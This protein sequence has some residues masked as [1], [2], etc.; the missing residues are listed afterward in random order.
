MKVA[1]ADCIWGNPFKIGPEDDREAVI[2]KYRNWLEND[3][4][5]QETA[6]RAK[7]ELKGKVLGEFKAISG[8][9]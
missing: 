1:A 8:I 4:K 6:C 5:G 2:R 7:R 3:P 9:V